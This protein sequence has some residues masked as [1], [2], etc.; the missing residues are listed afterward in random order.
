[1][2]THLPSNLAQPCQV[3]PG[4]HREVYHCHEQEFIPTP[5]PGGALA[6]TVA[7]IKAETVPFELVGDVGD[8]IPRL[9]KMESSSER[10][11]KV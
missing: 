2:D 7:R 4:S 9:A 5:K 11:D 1:M 8:V 3:W 10:G 6:A